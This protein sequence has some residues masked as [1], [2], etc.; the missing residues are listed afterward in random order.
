MQA[1]GV[2]AATLQYREQWMS[3]AGTAS[4]PEDAVKE[5]IHAVIKALDATFDLPD[6]S[7]GIETLTHVRTADDVAAVLAWLGAAKQ[8]GGPGQ[9]GWG[10][11]PPASAQAAAAAWMQVRCT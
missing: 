1:S 8:Q 5:R 4:L 6:T 3:P 11:P 2:D 7:E 10:T 9:V